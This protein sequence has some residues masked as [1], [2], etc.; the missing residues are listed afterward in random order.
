MNRLLIIFLALAVAYGIKTP[1][2]NEKDVKLKGGRINKHEDW[3]CDSDFKGPVLL[4][5]Q[6]DKWEPTQA[7][8]VRRCQID[9]NTYSCSMNLDR[10]L[11]LMIKVADK[12]CIPIDV[13][14]DDHSPLGFWI[15]VSAPEAHKFY[16]LFVNKKFYEEWDKASI[17]DLI[18]HKP[19]MPLH[20]SANQIHE[21]LKEVV[22]NEEKHTNTPPKCNS[23][24]NVF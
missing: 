9:A 19:G 22:K 5:P 16:E 24:A 1:F 17:K 15:T 11:M 14:L 20:N 23:M 8:Q 13:H 4:D 10:L 6:L 7:D 21:I 2:F 12:Y 18:L 3:V